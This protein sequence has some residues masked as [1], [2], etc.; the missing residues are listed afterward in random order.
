MQTTGADRHALR[1]AYQECVQSARSHYEN[2]PVASTFLPRHLRGPVAAIYVFARTADDF[3]DEGEAP[4]E[5]RLARLDGLASELDAVCAGQPA[6]TPQFL[7]L[8]DAIHRYG[9]PVQ[10]FHDLLTAFRMDVTQRRYSDFAAVLEYCRYSANP[11]GRLVLHL[12]GESTAENVRLSDAICSALQ[13][14]NFMQ[15]IAQDYAENDRIYLPLEDMAAFGVTPEDIGRRRND[16]NMRQVI[17]VQ[18]ERI[19]GLLRTGAPL[20]LRLRGRLGLQIRLTIY[21]ALSITTRLADPHADIYARPRLSLQ[22][23]I[24]MLRKALGGRHSL[25]R[26]TWPRAMPTPGEPPDEALRADE[27]VRLS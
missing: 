16:T 3:A 13:L 23:W 27:S 5:V 25:R 24:W 2:F 1:Q 8:A 17:A 9:L 19:L 22:N 7:A 21:G 20:G 12:G 14:I 10:L 11:V 26:L 18:L 4:P 15:D 6:Q